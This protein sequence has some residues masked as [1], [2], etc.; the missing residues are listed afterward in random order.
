MQVLFEDIKPHGDPKKDLAFLYKQIQV[1]EALAASPVLIDYLE[2]QIT[3][4]VNSLVD[5]T[6][7]PGN[8]AVKFRSAILFNTQ[9]L[10][11]FRHLHDLA[12]KRA[13]M[14]AA[15]EELRTQY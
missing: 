14:N 12:S 1:G 4:L 15:Y 9:Q 3:M 11:V 13:E 10:A 6:S 7:D 5:F 2:T 8:D